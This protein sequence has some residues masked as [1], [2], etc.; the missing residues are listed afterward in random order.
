M[1]A[2]RERSVGG[3]GMLM[4]SD[5]KRVVVVVAGW[6]FAGTSLVDRYFSYFQHYGGIEALLG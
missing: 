4:G 3:C 5:G 1:P 2:G 6:V